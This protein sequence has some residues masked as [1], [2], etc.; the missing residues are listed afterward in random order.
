MRCNGTGKPVASE[1]HVISRCDG[2]VRSWDVGNVDG[3]GEVHIGEV[4]GKEC[5]RYRS[6]QPMSRPLR[7]DPGPYHHV[8]MEAFKV[9]VRYKQKQ[10][11]DSL[12]RGQTGAV[13]EERALG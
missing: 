7:D 13:R 3:N 2:L 5:R 12:G 1:E 9:D 10:G 4:L 6:H 11:K 8:R